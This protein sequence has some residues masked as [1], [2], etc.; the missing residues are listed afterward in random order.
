RP[1]PPGTEQRLGPTGVRFSLDSPGVRRQVTRFTIRKIASG[2]PLL[3][4]LDDLHNASET[5]IDGLIRIHET[6]LDQRIF[7]VGTVRTEDVQLAGPIANAL[8]ALRSEIDGE[9]L[10]VLPMNKDDTCS[11]LRASLPLDD[12]AVLEAARRS[13]GFPLFALQQLHAWAHAGDMKFADGSYRVS[14]EVLA[15]RPQTTAD[16]WDARLAALGDAEQLAACAVATLG[17]DMRVVVIVALLEDLGLRPGPS[18]DALRR[19]EIILPRGTERY[20]WPHALL[21][22]HLLLRLASRPEA[23]RV[24][25]AA[26]RA[27]THHPLVG[28]HRVVRQRVVNLLHANRA[29]EAADIFFDFLEQSSHGTLQPRATLADLD[30]LAERLTGVA[31]ARHDR[32]RAEVLRYA[33]TSLQAKQHAE[34]AREALESLDDEP[35]LAHCLRLLG[36]LEANL[37]NL[38][39][40]LRQVEMAHQVFER[41]GDVLGMAECE[42][43]IAEIAYQQGNYQ[44]ASTAARQGADHFAAQGRMLGRAQCLLQLCW[45]AHSEGRSSRARRLTLEARTELER[46]GYRPG[47]AETTLLLAHIEHRLSNFFSAMSEAQDALALFEALGMPRG[48][49]ASERLLAM[50]AIDTDDL[51]N[52]QI[53]ASRSLR[54]YQMLV[55]PAG[56]AE[57]ELLLAQSYLARGELPDARALIEAVGEKFGEERGAKQHYLLTVAWLEMDLGNVERAQRALRAAA[58]CFSDLS[59]AGEHTSQLLARLSRL[60]WPMAEAFDLIEEWRRA[61]DDHERRDQ[62]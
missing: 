40:G 7:M 17:I 9:V 26:A 58:S 37:G 24:F 15:V 3:L 45:T 47:L 29:D 41:V 61:I 1:T 12:E 60:R 46:S 19:A 33:G 21:Q 62:D 38:S 22:E 20:T 13:R 55:E 8:R 10:Q 34:R 50:I 5:V 43:A 28:T 36:Q 6:E 59:Q 49:A 53:H 57:A 39:D 32:W 54:L 42:A 2:R 31:A 30:L 48:T 35:S 27:L 11:M 18:I 44:R 4:F 16:L 56:Q 52:A 23:E 25:Q 51:D 14:Q